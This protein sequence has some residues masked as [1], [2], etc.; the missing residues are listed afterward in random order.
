MYC[1]NCGKEIENDATF[2]PV[3]GSPIAENGGKKTIDRKKAMSL[4][5]RKLDQRRMCWMK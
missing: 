4:F 3:C 5:M 1:G 2:C